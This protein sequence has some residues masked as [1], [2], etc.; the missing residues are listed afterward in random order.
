M[1]PDLRIFYPT[2]YTQYSLPDLLYQGRLI[3]HPDQPQR[4]E[5][6]LTALTKAFPNSGLFEIA[7]KPAT[8]VLTSVHSLNYLTTVQKQLLSRASHP[9]FIRPSMHQIKASESGR[10]G[11]FCL[12]RVSPLSLPT[13]ETALV[14][15]GCALAASINMLETGAKLVYSLCRPPG[16]HAGAD[17][18]GGFCYLNNVALAAKRLALYGKVAVFDL[19]YHHGNGT[20]EVF[21]EAPNVWTGSIHGHPDFE[22]PYYCGWADEIGA[23]KGLGLNS[24]FPLP[25]NTGDETYLKVLDYQL[26]KLKAFKPDW[27]LISLGFDTFVDDFEGKFR[28]RADCYTKIGESLGQ[29]NKPLLVVQEGG[30]CLAELGNLA[31]NFWRG[32]IGTTI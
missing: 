10:L 18:Y 16:H 9:W 6:I 22:F 7:D 14:S 20:Q 13:W 29:L 28:L 23:G 12:D 30:Y 26:E 8:E 32:I 3:P 17:Y 21:W 31:T 27:V 24:N 5:V 2:N 15:A 19:D 4:V 25:A 1:Q 11:Y